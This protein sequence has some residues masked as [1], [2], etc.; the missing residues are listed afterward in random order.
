MSKRFP[1]ACPRAKQ[2]VGQKTWLGWAGGFA[3][4]GFKGNWVNTYNSSGAI[5][6]GA[7]QSSASGGAVSAPAGGWN[8]NPGDLVLRHFPAVGPITDFC[9]GAAQSY[10]EYWNVYICT[11]AITGS[12][13]DPYTDTAHFQ[14]WN[15]QAADGYQP[16][17]PSGWPAGMGNRALWDETTNSALLDYT[18][19]TVLN[20]FPLY[21]E[22]L[23]GVGAKLGYANDPSSWFSETT[24]QEIAG[25]GAFAYDWLFPSA[26]FGGAL[27][28]YD[29]ANPAYT[30]PSTLPTA[31]QSLLCFPS[32]PYM[33]VVSYAPTWDGSGNLLTVFNDSNPAWTSSSSPYPGLVSWGCSSGSLEFE[34]AAWFWNTDVEYNASLG[35]FGAQASA[36]ATVTQTLALGGSAYTTSAVAAQAVALMNATSFSS[37]AWRTSWTNTY[38]SA[39][40]LVSTPSTP[41]TASTSITE[42]GQVGT[43]VP[44]AVAVNGCPFEAGEL[45]YFSTQAQVDICGNYC[46]RTYQEGTSGPVACANGNVDGYAPFTLSPPATAGQS[47]AAYNGVQC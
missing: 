40:A 31:S 35:Y 34:F 26:T 39:G 25:S 13:T 46:L 24:T 42:A 44:W 32:L 6:G 47:R 28:V 8:F 36:P 27:G 30:P 3:F 11:S 7:W 45:T 9:T 12:A 20:D 23:T 29:G 21:P 18:V 37:I 43:P 38:N 1:C 17:A 4:P 33:R 2:I 16:S 5:T 41:S 19:T 15:W 22:S 14:P 10:P